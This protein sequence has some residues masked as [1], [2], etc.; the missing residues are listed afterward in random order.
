M[1]LQGRPYHIQH[2]N[3]ASHEDGGRITGQLVQDQYGGVSPNFLTTSAHH[4]QR[5]VDFEIEEPFS[6]GYF[7][8]PT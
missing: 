7:R 8:N 6:L 3:D 4:L 2:G 5:S 1:I